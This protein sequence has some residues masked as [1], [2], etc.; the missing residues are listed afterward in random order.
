[1]LD[2]IKLFNSNNVICSRLINS[3]FFNII[4]ADVEYANT[5]DLLLNQML[6]RC[7]L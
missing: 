3:I 4:L 6:M 2:R 1:M 5:G 7:L